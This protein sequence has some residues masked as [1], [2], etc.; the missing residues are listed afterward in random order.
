MLVIAKNI[1]IIKKYFSQ[2]KLYYEIKKIY[3]YRLRLKRICIGIC[4]GDIVISMEDIGI[5][6]GEISRLFKV[7]SMNNQKRYHTG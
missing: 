2:S 7:I 6:I 3:L 1:I 5:G 4:T